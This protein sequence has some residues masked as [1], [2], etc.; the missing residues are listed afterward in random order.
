MLG[1][2]A[3]QDQLE[4]FKATLKQIIDPKHPLLILAKAIPWKK[5][6]KK[7]EQL[8]SNTGAPSH[9]LSKMGGILLLLLVLL[10]G[11]SCAKSKVESAPGNNLSV[12]V[13]NL[14]DLRG[15]DGQT[16]L[17][18]AVAAGHQAIVETLLAQGAAIG[19]QDN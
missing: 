8:Y 19:E 12:Q 15:I 16:A 3:H 11:V 14:L 10:V 6:E 7:F 9:P 1:K 18:I 5:L 17:H 4:L 13:V 2:P